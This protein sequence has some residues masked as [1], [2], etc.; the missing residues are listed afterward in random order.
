MYILMC[1]HIN[2]ILRCHCKQI[3]LYHKKFFNLKIYKNQDKVQYTYIHTYVY[4]FKE[5]PLK[6][7]NITNIFLKPVH[8]GQFILTLFKNAI[9]NKIML[10]V[11]L[12]TI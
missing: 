8:G 10:N 1:V 2:L 9:F 3:S 6:F 5:K 4:C 12:F 11:L 7:I